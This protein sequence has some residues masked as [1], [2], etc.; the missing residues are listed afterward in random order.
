MSYGA[1]SRAVL[2]AASVTLPWAGDSLP[3]KNWLPLLTPP[4]A[5]RKWSVT[6]ALWLF[7]DTLEESRH[8]WGTQEQHLA[9]AKFRR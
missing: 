8:D 6:L 9:K 5:G 3:P 7:G 4:A 1:A 2:A